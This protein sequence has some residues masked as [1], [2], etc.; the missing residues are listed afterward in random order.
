MVPRAEDRPPVRMDHHERMRLRAAAY[1]A[2]RVYP[3]PV[4]ELIS[5]EIL[6][7]EEFG[8]RFGNTS[9]ILRLVDFV[10]KVE[11]ERPVTMST[12]GYGG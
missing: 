12:V 10:M 8:Y 7:W 1:R 3:G 11:M 5:R 4:G 9:F 2:T 6:I